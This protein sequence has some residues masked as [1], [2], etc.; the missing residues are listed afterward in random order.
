MCILRCHEWINSVYVSEMCIFSSK[1]LIWFCTAKFPPDVLACQCAAVTSWELG[2]IIYFSVLAVWC[3][4]REIPWQLGSP[5]EVKDWGIQWRCSGSLNCRTSYIVW[6]PVTLPHCSLPYS[7]PQE[8]FTF[9]FM[10]TI[11]FSEICGLLGYYAA[12]CGNWLPTF[13]DNVSVP[14]SRVKSPS[15]KESI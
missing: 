1:F 8:L 2:P 14:S 5:S 11:H 3:R 13:R 12:S 9:S 10:L 15:G 7:H 4:Y 6:V